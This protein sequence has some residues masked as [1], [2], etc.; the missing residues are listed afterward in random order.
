LSAAQLRSRRGTLPRR[1]SLCGF[2]CIFNFEINT[3]DANERNSPRDVRHAMG[4]TA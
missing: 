2:D 4:S 1:N 3:S